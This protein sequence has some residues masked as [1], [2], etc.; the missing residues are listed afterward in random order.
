MT[1]LI[2]PL[3]KYYHP[4]LSDYLCLMMMA[5]EDAYIKCGFEP[6]I[7]YKRMDILNAAIP[8][9]LERWKRDELSV[10]SE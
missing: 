8:F 3:E 6:N 1:R 10:I 7:D 4:D 5:I 9:V 2:S